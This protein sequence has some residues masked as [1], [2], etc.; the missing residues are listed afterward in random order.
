MSGTSLD[1]LDLAYC[2]FKKKKDE[3][4]FRIRAAETIKYSAEWGRKLSTSH[5]LPGVA[6]MLLD[7]EYGEFLGRSVLQFMR[8]H[9]GTVD[10]VA[11]HGHT[12]FHQPQRR[13]TFQ[14]GSGYAI[15]AITGLPTVFGFR[16]LD[17]ALGGEGAPMVPIG[18]RLLFAEYEGCLNLG[19]IANLSMEPRGKRLAFDICFA[20]M[21]LN[22]LSLK[23][24]LEY[25]QGG[26]L[27]ASGKVHAQML[28]AL[29][30]VNDKIRPRRPS[31]G[32]ELFDRQ[33]R[34]ILDLDEI[35]V[36][37]RLRTLTESIAMEIV[38][39]VQPLKDATVICTGGGVFNT[40]LMKRLKEMTGERVVWQ[41][42]ERQVVK[43]K[44]A[45]VFALLGLLRIQGEVNALKSVTRARL[46]NSGGAVLGLRMS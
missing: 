18:D 33:I 38:V 20:N 1:G 14:L 21:S 13:L 32:R 41:I 29:T 31:L 2:V 30:R 5:T 8:K 26:R 44:E 34:P 36:E 6:L 45:L 24:N 7:Q 11:S 28:E 10:L 22:Y 17:V 40:F 4:T 15:H 12:V 16:N 46:D 27:A 43:Y 19:G 9:K 39:S 25:D 35:S 3:W 23:L 42:P 37:D